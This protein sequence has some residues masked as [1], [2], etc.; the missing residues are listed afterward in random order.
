M[1]KLIMFE[2]LV[3]EQLNGTDAIKRSLESA[4]ERNLIGGDAAEVVTRITHDDAWCFEV[5]SY[6]TD[7]GGRVVSIQGETVARCVFDIVLAGEENWL[8]VIA[9]EGVDMSAWIDDLVHYLDHCALENELAGVL[10]M[11]RNGWERELR[12]F[13][14]RKRQVV[15]AR[16]VP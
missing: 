16:R 9:L 12:R 10:F 13:G 5:V 4:F 2:P 1:G 14:F 3:A 7:P 6:E 15:M 11:G 8:R